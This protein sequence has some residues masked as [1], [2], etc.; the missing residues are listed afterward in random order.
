MNQDSVVW[1]S[2]CL[3]AGTANTDTDNCWIWMVG[4]FFRSSRKAAAHGSFAVA[5]GVVRIGGSMTSSHRQAA[6]VPDLWARQGKGPGT[7]A[8]AGGGSDL[9]THWLAGWAPLS[10]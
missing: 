5:G 7:A 9:R 10:V 6:Q 1:N 8:V 3:R 2:S 4:Q